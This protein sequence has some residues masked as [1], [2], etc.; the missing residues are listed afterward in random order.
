M[1]LLVSILIS[2]FLLSGFCSAQNQNGK[3]S[4]R[5][6]DQGSGKTI[7]QE[8]VL[9]YSGDVQTMSA[10]TNQSGNF[11]FVALNPGEY[12]LKIQRN[13]YFPFTRKIRVNAN[14]T[15]KIDI[16]VKPVVSETKPVSAPA[17]EQLVTNKKE[18]IPATP[19]SGRP[20][21]QLASNSI[22]TTEA[23]KTNQS[24]TTELQTPVVD[25]E[26]FVVYPT[27]EISGN[28]EIE[29]FEAV[30]DQPVP[31]EGWKA[32]MKN[33]VY[34]QDAVKMNMQG[35]VYLKAW[36]SEQGEVTSL[37]VQKSIPMLDIAA[38]D[39]V[40]KTK[41]IP[42]KIGGSAVASILTIPVPF[43]LSK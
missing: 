10:R 40:Y 9:L 7:P 17:P 6:F 12:S 37:Q 8:M 24:K 13:G 33:V 29:Y 31:S 38:Q 16:S 4:G 42:G 25:T 28:T 30:E 34:P 22:T 27:E 15:T 36:I 26:D 1:K 39:A 18:T 23:V 43:R 14:F 2:G 11:S 3:I 35:T 32:L 19:D 20:L 5:V 21:V 41:F